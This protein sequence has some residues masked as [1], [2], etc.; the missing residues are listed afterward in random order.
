MKR[1]MTT[2]VCLILLLV[3]GC[4]APLTDGQVQS[5]SDRC[6]D[7]GMSVKVFHGLVNYVEC[8]PM[9]DVGN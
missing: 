9:R 1:T 6:K 7:L 3:A 4:S 5:V 2:I 8:V